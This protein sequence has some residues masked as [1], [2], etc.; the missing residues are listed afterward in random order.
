MRSQH[1]VQGKKVLGR[2]DKLRGGKEPGTRAGGQAA[3]DEKL[4]R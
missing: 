4:S 2:E 1:R 3:A